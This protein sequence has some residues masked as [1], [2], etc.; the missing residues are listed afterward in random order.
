MFIAF[1]RRTW[2]LR[3]Y[4][5]GCV[6]SGKQLLQC[7]TWLRKRFR[8]HYSPQKTDRSHPRLQYPEWWCQKNYF[9]SS[10]NWQHWSF[11]WGCVSFD[12]LFHSS[13]CPWRNKNCSY[14]RFPK[15][16]M[17]CYGRLTPFS[18]LV[19]FI[20]LNNIIKF[21][22]FQKTKIIP[23]VYF[24]IMYLYGSQNNSLW[25]F[26]YYLVY[27]FGRM[28]EIPQKDNYKYIYIVLYSCKKQLSK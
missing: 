9:C 24:K 8:N 28:G 4:P 19:H 18:L 15:N 3:K 5:T 13:R 26:F 1:V 10:S 16:S 2:C 14:G 12:S 22:K 20:H 27:E 21:I 7:T 17:W 11:T 23:K 6:L 25:N